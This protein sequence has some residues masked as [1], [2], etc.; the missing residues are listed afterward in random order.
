MKI[1][2]VNGSPRKKGNTAT[3][4]NTFWKGPAAPGRTRS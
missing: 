1:F 3:V 4:R 2:A